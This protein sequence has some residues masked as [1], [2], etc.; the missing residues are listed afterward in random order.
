MPTLTFDVVQKRP[1]TSVEYYETFI[2][3]NSTDPNY[4][5]WHK[6]VDWTNDEFINKWKTFLF[7]I[8]GRTWSDD[9][10]SHTSHMI[11][12]DTTQINAGALTDPETLRRE[13]FRYFTGPEMAAIDPDMPAYFQARA[14]YYTA[15]G[16]S[17]VIE[18]LVV[19]P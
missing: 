8:E 6:F 11:C 15:N 3:N 17:G 13:L 10:L 5:K 14:A 2:N 12:T 1:N 7:Q 4:A 18:N 16:L 19:H 9:K